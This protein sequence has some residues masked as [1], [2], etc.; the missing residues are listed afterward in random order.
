VLAGFG[1]LGGA[2]EFYNVDDMESMRSDAHHMATDLV[3]DPSGRFV[4]TSTSYWRH[5]LDN[6]FTIW[7]FQG[8]PLCHVPK[9]KFYQFLWRPRPPSLLANERLKHIEKNLKEY[10]LKYKRQDYDRKKIAWLA[11]KKKRDEERD[12][13]YVF[14]QERL[15]ECKKEKAQR[16]KLRGADSED[17]SQYYEYEE[18]V[19]EL[20]NE[21]EEVVDPREQI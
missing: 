16:V 4:A 13:F 3:W 2:L 8:K 6:G 7:T 1:V 19:E 11:F 10:S 20:L 17:E 18:E 15:E 9:D 12:A 5:Q 14:K 21:S